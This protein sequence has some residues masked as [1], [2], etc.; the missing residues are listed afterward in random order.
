VQSGGSR[1]ATDPPVAPQV[2]LAVEQY[3]RIVRMLEKN[4]PVTLQMDIANRF[5]DADLN[6][7]NVIG[8]LPGSDKA[9]EV[10]MIGAHFDSWHAGTGATDN[11]AG[12]AVVMEAM[13]ILKATGST[14]DARSESDCGAARRGPARSR[15]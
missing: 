11:A 14:F 13:R 2:V 6:A 5:Y 7:Y 8:E 12:S 4:T 10:V 15:A 3:G 9:A 1:N